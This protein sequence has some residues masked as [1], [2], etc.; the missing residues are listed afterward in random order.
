MRLV[1]FLAFYWFHPL[2]WKTH[3][4]V[5][6]NNWYLTSNN[7]LLT[8]TEGTI[9]GRPMAEANCLRWPHAVWHFC[10]SA[11][12]PGPM[13][14][15]ASALWHQKKLPVYCSCTSWVLE[16]LKIML[17]WPALWVV[18]KIAWEQFVFAAGVVA[19]CL[20]LSSFINLFL[21][22]LSCIYFVLF[23]S[24]GL[25]VK[26]EKN[27]KINKQMS[28]NG[29]GNLIKRFLVAYPSFRGRFSC[30]IGA[31]TASFGGGSYRG[32]LMGMFVPL[33][34]GCVMTALVWESTT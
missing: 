31:C 12:A 20:S 8:E 17:V 33:Y 26:Q 10:A 5:S 4:S 23:T 9:Q 6:N 28:R 13:Q 21:N 1:D 18:V 30:A 14:T 16:S 32:L 15:A 29:A 24:L 11:A 34:W 27:G 3:L 25:L 22:C 19:A 2:A 7:F